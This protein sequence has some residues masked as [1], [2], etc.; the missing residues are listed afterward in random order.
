MGVGTAIVEE[1][2]CRELGRS[3]KFKLRVCH[4]LGL[5]DDIIGVHV[6]DDLQSKIPIGAAHIVVIGRIDYA[7]T[8]ES[9]TLVAGPLAD[10]RRM[11]VVR[12]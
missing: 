11:V 4:P 5:P 3:N 7:Y 8:R 6:Q 2:L 10:Y 9:K 1:V 12:L